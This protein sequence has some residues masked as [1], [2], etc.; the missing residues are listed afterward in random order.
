MEERTLGERGP[1]ET[2]LPTEQSAS[3]PGAEKS[4]SLAEA[5]EQAA[6]RDAN[7]APTRSVFLFPG[8]G[9]QSPGMGRDLYDALP[10]V[11]QTVDRASALTG[12]DLAWHMFNGD[13]KTLASPE[14]AQLAVYTLSTGLAAA[15][16]ARGVRP[17]AVAGHSLGEYSAL[18]AAGCLTWET[19]LRL[20]RLRGR[21]MAL[22]AARRAGAMAAIVGLPAELVVELC[23]RAG[24]AGSV[25]PAN[26]NSSLQT[27][28]A[29]DS[30]AVERVMALTEA[31]GATNVVLPVGGAFHSPH[32]APAE[33]ALRPFL[34][35]A[36]LARPTVTLLS[37]VTGSPVVDVEQYRAVLKRQMTRPVDWRG[38]MSWLIGAGVEQFIE[39]GPGRVLSGLVRAIDRAAGTTSVGTV[40]ALECLTAAPDA[41][42]S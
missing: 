14:V 28:V 25:V 17:W 18:A 8:Q 19:G 23:T 29:G 15:L 26:F 38:V 9:S 20:V 24:P 42:F 10:I 12:L 40:R 2:T 30:Q 27:V 13:E 4:G 6:R 31:S 3:H 22:A 41:S 39:V 34:A 1:A 7:P 5:S 21:A 36:R 32:M 37:S 11:R 16:V 35:R 33:R